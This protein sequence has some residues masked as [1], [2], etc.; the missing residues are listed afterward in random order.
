MNS[1]PSRWQRDALPL[2]YSR[3]RLRNI[4]QILPGASAKSGLVQAS[5]GALG[6]QAG[7]DL[8]LTN[9]RRL[10]GKHIHGI[11]FIQSLN[12]AMI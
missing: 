6:R 2:S 1:R 4:G 10:A 9:D 11:Q 7:A 12:E 5:E 8:F 3:V